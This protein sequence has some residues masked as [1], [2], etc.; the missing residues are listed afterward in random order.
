MGGSGG[1]DSTAVD[2]ARTPIL[3]ATTV[4]AISRLT[5]PVSASS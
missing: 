5:N 2:V 1:P 4:A 3:F